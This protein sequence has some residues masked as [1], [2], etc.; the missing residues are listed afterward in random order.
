MSKTKKNFENVILKWVI[1][2]C[3]TLAYSYFRI[4]GVIHL[5]ILKMSKQIADYM[6][7]TILAKRYEI[8]KDNVS[9]A[10]LREYLNVD[11]SVSLYAAT[12]IIYRL[13]AEGYVSKPLPEHD[14]KRKLLK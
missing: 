6:Y 3:Q 7:P 12:A 5:E 2:K 14:F 11:H 13:E 10:L 4:G 9:G 8:F 1:I